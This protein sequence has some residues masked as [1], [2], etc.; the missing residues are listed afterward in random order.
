MSRKDLYEIIKLQE[1]EFP[2]VTKFNLKT[3]CK[4]CA[5]H[6]ASTPDE[7]EMTIAYWHEHPLPHQ[8]H[9]RQD[10]FACVGAMEACRRLGLMK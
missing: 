5:Y 3:K 10:G 7:D 4:T 8:C 6:T 9:E 2:P 1:Y